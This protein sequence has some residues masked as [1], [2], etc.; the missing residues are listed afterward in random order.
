MGNLSRF[1]APLRD[2]DTIV[3]WSDFVDAQSDVFFIDTITDTGTVATGDTFGGVITLTPGQGGSVDD[4]DEAIIRSANE[5]FLFA[6]GKP[7]YAKCKLAFTE[8]TATIYN[9]GF[10]FMNAAATDPLGDDGGGA[11]LTGSTAAIYKTD[12]SGVW[13]CATACNSV[14]TVSTSTSTAVTATDYYL[15]IFG[16]DFS[17]TQMVFTFKVNGNYLLDSTSGAVIRH[18]V[19]VASATEMNLWASCKLGAATNNDTT[20]IDYIYGHQYR[21]QGAA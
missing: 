2:L 18:M 5:V 16:E 14:S 19:T 17:S 7:M 1:A 4:N 12:A 20:R 15:E 9:V 8:T 10:G 21:G 13:K 3:V 6:A 11:K